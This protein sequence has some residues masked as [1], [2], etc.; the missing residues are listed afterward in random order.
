MD[1]H[2]FD[3]SDPQHLAGFQRVTIPEKTDSIQAESSVNLCTRCAAMDFERI[4]DNDPADREAVPYVLPLGILKENSPC[5][6]CRFFY[7]MRYLEHLEKGSA[8]PE[9]Y[10][11]RMF[12]LGV[13]TEYWL[14]PWMI[15]PCKRDSPSSVLCVLPGLE[16][17]AHDAFW[18]DIRSHHWII[19][20][21]YPME[22]P[23][24]PQRPRLSALPTPPTSI[25][26]PLLRAWYEQ[27]DAHH[28]YCRGTRNA[29]TNNEIHR[30]SSEI[31]CIDVHERRVV[32]VRATDRY[33]AL[34]YVWGKEIAQSA[35]AGAG[36]SDGSRVLPAAIPKVIEDAI[37]VVAGLGE[38]YLWADLYCID[39]DN[40][41]DKH[42]QISNMDSIYESAHATIVAFSGA[43]ASVGLPGVSDQPR[44]PYPSEH[45]PPTFPLAAIRPSVVNCPS[46][47]YSS[48]WLTR[49]WTYQE[50]VLSRR[51]LLFTDYQVEFICSTSVWHECMVPGVQSTHFENDE[52]IHP[53]TRGH[54]W[55]QQIM[56]IRMQYTDGR[57]GQ[58]WYELMEWFT[59]YSCRTLTY[60]SDAL[61][62]VKGLIARSSYFTYM[63]APINNPV[64]PDSLDQFGT[65]ALDEKTIGRMLLPFLRALRW[66]SN[67]YSLPLRRRYGFPSWSW[68]G[69]EG[70]IS[71]I[72]GSDNGR[73][74]VWITKEAPSSTFPTI[75]GSS[76]SNALVP[77][78]EVALE[79]ML[80]G[81]TNPTRVIPHWNNYLWIEGPVIAMRFEFYNREVWG[82]KVPN[83]RVREW[84]LRKLSPPPVREGLCGPS[85]RVAFHLLSPK[86]CERNPAF[87]NRIITEQWECILLMTSRENDSIRFQV[88][89]LQ[90][91]LG[92]DGSSID[93]ED[94]YTVVGLG[95]VDCDDAD[96]VEDVFRDQTLVRRVKLG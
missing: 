39:Q 53:G 96:W 52:R 2:A 24:G 81:D 74:N 86:D 70:E 94:C 17:V 6:L 75:Q 42:D 93:V 4:F 66:R 95:W 67:Y 30:A 22:N 63:G 34:S 26:Y 47:T 56:P 25:N 38:R 78:V 1:Q 29:R 79:H 40:E 7:S 84:S 9:A 76:E 11:L 27:C 18:R 71:F 14:Q 10:H 46:L 31:R 21:F 57:F 50:A 61:N 3:T 77:L 28:N 37:L 65:L 49:G 59:A 92:Q 69:W 43:D 12:F 8:A 41:V 90:P 83:F 85:S 87:F 54:N 72:Y 20:Q 23:F 62:A 33:F 82:K 16:P 64:A 48:V 44:K 35:N 58:G 60:D 45:L 91:N 80:K 15:P 5:A 13:D 32:P 68:L 55:I 89:D 88:I 19:P 36:S 51:L 73:V